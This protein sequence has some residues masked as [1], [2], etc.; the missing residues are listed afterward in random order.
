MFQWIRNSEGILVKVS[1]PQESDSEL[2]LNLHPIE[3]P[4]EEQQS[5]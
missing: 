4:P 1:I 5:Q 2:S 3:P